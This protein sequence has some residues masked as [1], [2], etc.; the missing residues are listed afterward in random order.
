MPIFDY[1]CSCCDQDFDELVSLA[2]SSRNQPCPDCGTLSSKTFSDFGIGAENTPERVASEKKAERRHDLALPV[3]D[4]PP[5]I[6]L[7]DKPAVPER[8]MSH[9]LEHGHC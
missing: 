8:Y 9:V 2:D 4:R 5:K 7:G 6:S 1:H 3:K